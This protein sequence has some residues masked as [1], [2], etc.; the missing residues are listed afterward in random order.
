MTRWIPVLEHERT[1]RNAHALRDVLPLLLRLTNAFGSNAVVA[2]LLDVDPALVTRWRNGTAEI[3]PDM[4]RRIVDLQ[5]AFNRA[6]QVFAPQEAILWLLGSEPFL[7]GARPLD[8][9]AQKG[10]APLIEALAAIEADGYA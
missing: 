3:S 5:D 10:A 2:R 4:K 8:V 6:F 7:G 9:L 1:F